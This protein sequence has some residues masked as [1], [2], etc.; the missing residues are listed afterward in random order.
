MDPIKNLSLFLLMER[1]I[2]KA[3][4]LENEYQRHVFRRGN[5]TCTQV[6]LLK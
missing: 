3:Q 4:D 6:S 2:E 5:E 1:L